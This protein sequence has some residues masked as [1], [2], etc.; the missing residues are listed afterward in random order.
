MELLEFFFYFGAFLLQD[1]IGHFVLGFLLLH[2]LSL[3]V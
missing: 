3:R 2:L 1:D